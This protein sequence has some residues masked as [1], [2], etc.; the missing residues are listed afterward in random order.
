M[1]IC[2]TKEILSVESDSEMLVGFGAL[3]GECTARN[4]SGRHKIKKME[5]KEATQKLRL[6][7]VSENITLEH[8]NCGCLYSR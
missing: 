1:R 3:D 4:I 6:A 7:Y 2:R 8:T 5:I